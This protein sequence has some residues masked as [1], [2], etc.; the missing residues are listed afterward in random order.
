MA[1][2]IRFCN[3]TSADPTAGARWRRHKADKNHTIGG[4]LEMPSGSEMP[5]HPKGRTPGGKR[6]GGK[7]SGS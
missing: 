7:V 4:K 6:R 2:V 5:P 3:Q 1:R